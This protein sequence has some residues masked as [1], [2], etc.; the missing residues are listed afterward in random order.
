MLV[1]AGE[2]CPPE[3]VARWA[4]GRRMFNGYG[5]SEAT[6]ET[7]VSPQLRPGH[8]VTIGGPP[9]VSTR[10]SSTTGCGPVP[11]GVAAE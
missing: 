1:V 4:P 9:S 6:I 7:S 5:P 11:F 8:T 2:A 3:L 10:P